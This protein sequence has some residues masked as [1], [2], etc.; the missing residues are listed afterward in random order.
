MAILQRIE[1][2]DALRIKLASEGMEVSDMVADGKHKGS[3]T[4]RLLDDE[5]EDKHQ[6]YRVTVA[7]PHGKNFKLAAD[8]GEYQEAPGAL[9]DDGDGDTDTAG[10]PEDDEIPF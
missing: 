8:W 4:L 9:S 10:F 3:F 6:V 7:I 1:L 2:A 5:N